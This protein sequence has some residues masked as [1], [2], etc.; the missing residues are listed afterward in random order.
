MHRLTASVRKR[1]SD[2]TDAAANQFGGSVWIRVSESGY[3]T[4][5]LRKEV[6]GFEFEEI[7]VN[8][9]HVVLVLG[10]LF[11]I[12]RLKMTNDQRFFPA[13]VRIFSSITLIL[14][15][16]ATASKAEERVILADEAISIALPMGWEESD[17]NQEQVLAGFA[18]QD[19]R[20]SVFFTQFEATSQ[21]YM[22]DL[23]DSTLANFEQVY[24]LENYSKYKKGKVK[25][26][27][28]EHD[29]IFATVEGIHEKADKSTFEMKFYLL[30]FNVEDRYYLLQA[31][32]TMPI[33]EARERQIYELIRS[34]VAK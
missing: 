11:G 30:A 24:R 19:S 25:G 4:T 20:T 12:W 23:I 16:F 5:D 18:T 1:F 13:R 15:V 33:R 22:V 8:A 7:V 14:A 21:S 32:T 17:L 9:C 34:I 28:K 3:S 10:I 6:T 2:I 27:E 29:A 26:I 31:S